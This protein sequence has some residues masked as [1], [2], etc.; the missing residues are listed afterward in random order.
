MMSKIKL[1]LSTVVRIFNF[2][3][4]LYLL[5]SV[6]FARQFY[7]M[8]AYKCLLL[9]L[10]CIYMYIYIDPEISR[11]MLVSAELSG[12]YGRAFW[13]NFMAFNNVVCRTLI[14]IYM[15]MPI[16]ITVL[17]I[18][19]T[20][21]FVNRKDILVSGI[22]VLVINIYVYS[23]LIQGIFSEIM[24]YNVKIAKIPAGGSIDAGIFSSLLLWILLMTVFILI[25]LFRPY[26]VNERTNRLIFG[27]RW[28]HINQNLCISLHSYKNAFFGV[29][30]QCR[31]AEKN[32]N[33]GEYDRALERVRMGQSIANEHVE[34]LCNLLELIGKI[35]VKY[36]DVSLGECLENAVRKVGIAPED[37]IVIGI[38]ETEDILVYGDKGHLTEM[39]FNII[40]NSVEALKIKNIS[41]ARINIDM[42]SEDGLVQI[43]IRDNGVGIEPKN[44]RKIFRPFNST[45]TK[46]RGG[47]GLNYVSNVVKQHHGETRV[48]SEFGNYTLFQLVF[49][50]YNKKK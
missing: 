35:K 8:K 41:G 5:M 33:A 24:F 48:K 18:R 3:L 12:Y 2:F 44:I 23:V 17:R 39:F 40:L 46:S 11:V 9:C 38:S 26:W 29:S 47:I 34:A 6:I 22:C 28:K 36:T 50:V 25:V 42:F 7:R 13:N 20:K 31:I 45:K 16:I 14:I 21:I 49:P 1:P 27:Y 4:A 10:P 43:D 30:Q 15:V 37:N 32:I 19:N